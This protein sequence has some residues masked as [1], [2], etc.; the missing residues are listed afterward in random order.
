MLNN[1]IS[2]GPSWIVQPTGTGKSVIPQA[3]S[4]VNGGVAAVI[5]NTLALSSDQ[6][7]KLERL[8]SNLLLA[9]Q[10]DQL[11]SY[12]DKDI[13]R[14]LLNSMHRNKSIIA[15]MIFTSPECLMNE[16]WARTMVTSSEM[17]LIRCICID[18]VHQFV[19]FG[20]TFRKGFK[21][22]QKQLK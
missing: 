20:I 19:M 17:K 1:S 12:S 21:M 10:L 4:L 15:T 11:K 6:V 9:V 18:E 16:F 13:C 5:K 8:N 7:S 14:H 3:L 22:F 2:I